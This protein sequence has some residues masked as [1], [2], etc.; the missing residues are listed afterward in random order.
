MTELSFLL[1]IGTE[2]LPAD[3]VTS[4]IAQWQQ[5]IPRSLNEHY[6][7]HQS[8][9]VYG[10]PRRLAVLIEGLLANQPDRQET[11]KGPP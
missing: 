10:T 2:E 11:V 3:F 6:L 5:S 8:V 4:A 9:K 1:E 7:P